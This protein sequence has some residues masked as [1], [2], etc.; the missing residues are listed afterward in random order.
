VNCKF[1]L[2]RF[3]YLS[4]VFIL[5][6]TSSARAFNADD[7]ESPRI[8]T[9]RSLVKPSKDNN[10]LV[11]LLISTRDDKNLVQMPKMEINYAF[12]WK[13]GSNPP[14][15]C[16]SFNNFRLTLSVEE[17]RNKRIQGQQGVEQTFYAF[18]TLPKI[19]SLD[20]ACQEYRDFARPPAV[21][22]NAP[23][24]T[25]NITTKNPIPFFS[26][27][28]ISPL[29]IDESGRKSDTNVSNISISTL[30]LY[31]LPWPEKNLQVCLTAN[32]LSQVEGVNAAILNYE[33]EVGRAIDVGLFENIEASK[34][35]SD[36]RNR[37]KLYSEFLDDQGSKPWEL[38]PMCEVMLSPQTIT[39]KV[40]EWATKQKKITDETLKQ[41]L[42]DEKQRQIQSAKELATMRASI[43]G[44]IQEKVKE[45][46]IY[47]D[48]LAIEV[49]NLTASPLEIQS[50]TSLG[51][52]EKSKKLAAQSATKKLDEAKSRLISEWN[53]I[54]ETDRVISLTMVEQSGYTDKVSIDFYRNYLK[55]LESLRT[56]IERTIVTLLKYTQFY[57][58]EIE[59]VNRMR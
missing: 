54:L 33:K 50:G 14:P 53:E 29:L 9:M 12:Q 5:T 26:G 31:A 1:R 7:K 49:R 55:S 28:I 22:M 11:F 45:K 19:P 20:T 35:V 4:F 27:R 6:F 52:T 48:K 39:K 36:Y 51:A 10:G 30:D 17:V 16:S 46:N 43:V 21:S 57:L 34:D 25:S 44:S 8:E 40:N 38:V 42:L 15:K 41:M 37:I 56:S 18:G 32:V 2:K 24:S 58:N 23:I 47:S 13:L 3:I 59:R